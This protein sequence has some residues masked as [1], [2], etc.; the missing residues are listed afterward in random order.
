MEVLDR[1]TTVL[2]VVGRRLSAAA[3]E[4]AHGAAA[5]NSGR[6]FSNIAR[7]FFT[8]LHWSAAHAS[9]QAEEQKSSRRVINNKTMS[10]LLHYTHPAEVR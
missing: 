6:N 5:L 1:K 3:Y 10:T 2:R 4:Y 7:A 8:L 9:V